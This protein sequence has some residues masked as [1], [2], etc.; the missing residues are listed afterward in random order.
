MLLNRTF[1]TKPDALERYTQRRKHISRLGWDDAG[2]RIASRATCEE[3]TAK[4]VVT[5]NIE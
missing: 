5:R 4:Q 3:A 1:V 2:S